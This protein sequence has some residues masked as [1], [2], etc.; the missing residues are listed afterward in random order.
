MSFLRIIKT[1]SP[2]EPTPSWRA[3]KHNRGTAM[4]QTAQV[5]DHGSTIG[6][7][8]RALTGPLLALALLVAGVW[9][10][11]AP[12]LWWDEG[13]T[14]SVA[15][16]WVERGYY[17]R[18]LDGQLVP[19]GLQASFTVTG[20]VA[21]SLRLFGIG[22]W[23]GRL[24][25]VL[26]TAA[27]IV[28][29]YSLARHLYNHAVA[30]GTIFVLFLLS[31]HPQLHP[32]LI[33]RQVLAEMPMLL[34]LLAG[35]I[36]F[37]RALQSSRWWLPLAI[38]WWGIALITKAQVLPFWIVS[39]VIP[40]VVVLIRRR[41]G[42]AAMLGAGLFGAYAVSRILL[43]GIDLLLRRYGVVDNTGFTSVHGLYA[44]TALV[45]VPFNR[46]FALQIMLGFGLPTLLGLGYALFRQFFK[47]DQASQVGGVEVVRL[48]LLALAGSWL[49][50]FLL[51]SVGV[52]RYL[53]P[54]TFVGS[55]FV[56]A[57][58]YDLTDGF[59]IPATLK[60]SSSA[61]ARLRFDRRSSSALLAII[62]IAGTLPITLLTLMRY[63]VPNDTSAV[64]VATF[65]D[66]QTP[67]D[68]LIETYESELHFLLHRRYH[69]P[70]DQTHV[71]LNRR[72]LVGQ[73]V[74]IDYDPLAENPDYLVVGR[75]ARGNDLYKP[76]LERGA[77][78]LLR[79][80]GEYAIYQRVP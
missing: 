34:F 75:F 31:M 39:L 11:D 20:P 23:Q 33:G 51:L 47:P 45:L 74:I 78:T 24:F 80:Y 1:S 44:V 59:N 12:P 77:F 26:C 57:L 65:F 48:M 46:L 71:E 8:R 28:L 73:D 32:L 16:T 18:V 13:W 38:V 67:P 21:L 19:G 58:L 27:A 3:N 9:R 36:C 5:K 30:R 50:W 25:G 79:Q 49:S 62:L 41:W 22:I 14:L 72:S 35:Y 63:Y 66:T 15:R 64:D 55:I 4:A 76:V 60:R 61:L 29:I 17:G 2:V 43:L 7:Q 42:L 54:V 68:T 53:F 70:P 10:L 69:F 56:A 37:L 52:P 40:L 6:I